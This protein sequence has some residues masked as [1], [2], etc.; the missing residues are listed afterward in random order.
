MT[1]L[2]GILCLL[3][4]CFLDATADHITGGEVYYK[5]TSVTNGKYNYSVTL[6]VFMRC[7]SGR[8]FNNPATISVFDK[9]SSNRIVDVSVNL[10]NQEMIELQN[11][12][13]CITK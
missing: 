12:S 6:K 9:A 10:G 1:K 5:L 13:R 2:F 7:G 4:F 8:Q 11:P 3:I